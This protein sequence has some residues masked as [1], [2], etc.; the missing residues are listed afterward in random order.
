MNA[1][2]M[3]KKITQPLVSLLRYFSIFGSSPFSYVVNRSSPKR[4]NQKIPISEAVTKTNSGRI[5]PLALFTSK[6]RLQ[7]LSESAL[8]ELPTMYK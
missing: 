2:A 1:T 5:M 8:K 3:T 4:L 6:K 7:Q